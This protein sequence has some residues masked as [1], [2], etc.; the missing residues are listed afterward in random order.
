MSGTD[1]PTCQLAL[2]LTFSAPS[3]PKADFGTCAKLCAILTNCSLLTSDPEA[4]SYGADAKHE[5]RP[6]VKIARPICLGWRQAD[7]FLLVGST[8]GLVPCFNAKD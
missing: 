7:T 6:G 5:R 8:T 2:A 1:E 3:S 4:L